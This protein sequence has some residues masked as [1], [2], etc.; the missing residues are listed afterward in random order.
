MSKS[1]RSA[2]V[3]F[4]VCFAMA[5]GAQDT[6]QIGKDGNVK[7]NSVGSK[8]DIRGGN[9]KVES[10]GTRTTVETKQDDD[11]KEDSNDDSNSEIDIT[12]AG[13]KETLACNGTTEVSIG[14]SS[15]ELTFTGACKRVDVTGSS[16]KVTLDAVEQIDVTGTGNTVTWKKAAGGRKKPKV[17]ATGTDN[18]VSQR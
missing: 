7:V 16:N 3:A 14:G 13:R 11:D 5:A 6:V 18:R 15:N 1:I 17:S 12:G 10:E 4:T 2:A 9:V 8:V